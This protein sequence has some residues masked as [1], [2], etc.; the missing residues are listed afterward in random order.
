MQRRLASGCLLFNKASARAS[1]FFSE[2]DETKVV[3]LQRRMD[4][5]HQTRLNIERQNNYAGSPTRRNPYMRL[6][7]R[8]YEPARLERK[9]V[10]NVSNGIRLSRS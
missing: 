8:R 3:F 2:S 7:A 10:V 9:N 1:R 4:E 6:R 5:S